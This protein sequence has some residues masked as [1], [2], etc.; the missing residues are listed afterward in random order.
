MSEWEKERKKENKMS[1]M[2]KKCV[3][4]R[5]SEWESES[6][7]DTLICQEVKIDRE[8]EKER[9]KEMKK[10]KQTERKKRMATFFK[11]A[12]AAANSKE[13]QVGNILTL[14]CCFFFK[15]QQKWRKKLF[16]PKKLKYL[17]MC[18]FHFISF[19]FSCFLAFLL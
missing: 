5:R 11:V 1:E 6:E 12:P 13:I 2:K 7:N 3:W 19:H 14:V 8:S 9:E 15:F 4:E 16:H 10:E 17:S 18:L